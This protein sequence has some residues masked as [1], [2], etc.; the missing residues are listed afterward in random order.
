MGCEGNGYPGL[1]VEGTSVSDVVL[2]VAKNDVAS[3]GGSVKMGVAA[4]VVSVRVKVPENI[5]P[6]DPEC[7]LTPEFIESSVSCVVVPYDQTMSVTAEWSIGRKLAVTNL[8]VST[9]RDIEVHWT[10]SC[11]QIVAHTITPRSV[12]RNTARAPLIDFSPH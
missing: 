11:H 12:L 6:A 3:A 5:C 8:V 2:E 7:H 4:D 10:I 1:V 9:L